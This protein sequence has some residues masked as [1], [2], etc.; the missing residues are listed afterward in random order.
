MEVLFKTSQPEVISD[1]TQFIK[2]WSS[3]SFQ[4]KVQTSGSTGSPKTLFFT[5]EQVQASALRTLKQFGISE[6]Q[7]ALLCLSTTT[8]AGKMMLARSVV[9]NLHLMVAAPHSNPLKDIT[10]DIDFVALVPYQ[11]NEILNKNPEKLF[12]IKTILVGGAPVSQELEN[13]LKKHHLT[14]YHTFGMTETLSHFAVRKMGWNGGKFYHALNGVRFHSID[15]ELVIDDD[16]LGIGGLK[17]GELV[18]LVSSD[19]FNWLGRKDFLINSG[20]LSIQPEEIERAL[21]EY[22]Q[23]PFFVTGLPHPDLGEQ[24]TL[25]IEGTYQVSFEQV[26]QHI[27]KKHLRPKKILHLPTFKYTRNGKLDRKLTL[28][29]LK[30]NAFE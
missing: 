12:A 7:S 30:G 23:S 10:E 19:T 18:D 11:L 29:L 2:S 26:C 3:D 8:I 21:S 14:V 17:S 22:I 25:I 16:V 9:G 4:L 24:I 5:K 15:N 28:E 27:A 20:G 6:N 1:V 13:K